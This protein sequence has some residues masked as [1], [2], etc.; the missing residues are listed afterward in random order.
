MNHE[1]DGKMESRI[2]PARRAERKDETM[3]RELY[4]LLRPGRIVAT[5]LAIVL[6]ATAGA[7]LARN[8]GGRVGGGNKS[9]SQADRW[10]D[11]ATT[12]VERRLEREAAQITR[13]C[14]RYVKVW[15]SDETNDER[16]RD[17]TY[18]EMCSYSVDGILYLLTEDVVTDQTYD[19]STKMTFHVPI[20]ENPSGCMLETKI[21][22]LY[23]LVAEAQ[24]QNRWAWFLRSKP[25]CDEDDELEDCFNCNDK[26]FWNVLYRLSDDRAD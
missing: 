15:N 16:I 21:D 12:R 14:N 8:G 7:A 19:I 23:D 24:E 13:V 26:D 18:D 22:D 4:T 11:N 1:L 5:A 9:C 3:P 25:W 6:I 10:V 2:E 17:I 20:I